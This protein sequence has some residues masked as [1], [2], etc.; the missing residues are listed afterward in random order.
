M[1]NVNYNKAKSTLQTQAEYTESLTTFETQPGD[2]QK[3][4]HPPPISAAT[5]SCEI[6]I[7]GV[8]AIIGPPF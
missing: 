5:R 8:R 1:N 2:L 4:W 6:F 7:T 3:N